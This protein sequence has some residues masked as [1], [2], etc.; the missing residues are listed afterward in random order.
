MVLPHAKKL[1]SL[2]SYIFLS[3]TGGGGGGGGGGINMHCGIW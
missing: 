3:S 1:T 2:S